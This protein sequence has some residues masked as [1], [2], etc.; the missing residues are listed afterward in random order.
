MEIINYNKIP[1]FKRLFYR[2]FKCGKNAPQYIIKIE[3]TLISRY[4]T[5][6]PQYAY[7]CL[8]KRCLNNNISKIDTKYTG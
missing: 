4:L 5:I 1:L 8:C 7:R 2:C 6:P 3:N